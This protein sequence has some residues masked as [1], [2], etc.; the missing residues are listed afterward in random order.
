MLRDL[1]LEH[2][3]FMLCNSSTVA[4]RKL[5]GLI[6]RQRAISTLG[7]ISLPLQFSCL[8]LKFFTSPLKNEALLHFVK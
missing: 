4:R 5:P 1:D 2:F 6:E 8:I 7:Y 3:V